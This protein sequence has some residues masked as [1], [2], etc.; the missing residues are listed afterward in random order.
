MNQE[1]IGYYAR[2]FFPQFGDRYGRLAI[3]AILRAHG[4]TVFGPPP[5]VL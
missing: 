2:K 1:Q 5:S 3:I 4:V